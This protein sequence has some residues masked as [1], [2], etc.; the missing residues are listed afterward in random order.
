MR[1]EDLKVPSLS[2]LTPLAHWHIREAPLPPGPPLAGPAAYSVPGCAW[3]AAAAAAYVRTWLSRLNY[4]NRQRR[5]ASDGGGYGVKRC[6]H[7]IIIIRI[8]SLH[9]IY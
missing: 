1:R 6:Q 8:K 2:Q 7:F 3:Q 4:K 5:C 9:I